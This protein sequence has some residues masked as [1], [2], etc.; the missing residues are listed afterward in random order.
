MEQ[1][2]V[3]RIPAS[4]LCTKHSLSAKKVT[5]RNIKFHPVLRLRFN[6]SRHLMVRL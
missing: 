3:L 5:G 1:S 4:N 6:E 2:T